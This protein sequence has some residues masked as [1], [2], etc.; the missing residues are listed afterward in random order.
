MSLARVKTHPYGRFGALAMARL[1]KL[2]DRSFWLRRH[3]PA[4]PAANVARRKRTGFGRL[5]GNDYAEHEYGSYEEVQLAEPSESCMLPE[6]PAANSASG[7]RRSSSV[8]R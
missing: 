5:P 6:A 1:P 3:S 4:R 8:I 2:N 7:A